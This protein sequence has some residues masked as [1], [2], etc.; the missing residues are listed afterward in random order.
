MRSC[1]LGTNY[2]TFPIYDALYLELA[3]RSNLELAT[4]E[5][6]LGQAAAR[7]GLLMAT[8]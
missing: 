4:L 3:K 8:A 1:D 6:R 2:M 7:E 5:S